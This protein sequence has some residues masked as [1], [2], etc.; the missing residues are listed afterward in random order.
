MEEVRPNF[1]FVGAARTGSTSLWNWLNQHPDVFM[2]PVKEPHHFGTHPG[3]KNWNAY[4]RLFRD[5]AGKSVVGEASVSYLLQPGVPAQIRETLGPVK[6]VGMLRQNADRLYSAWVQALGNGR[7]RG[8]SFEAAVRRDLRGDRPA[9]YGYRAMGFVEG[10]KYAPAVA[11]YYEVFG[12]E[13]VRM[14][15]TDDLH[16]DGGRAGVFGDLCGFLGITH[17]VRVD[18]RP[19]N[20]S[21]EKLPRFPGLQMAMAQFKDMA[22]GPVL[23]PLGNAVRRYPMGWNIAMGRPR[24]P[25]SPALRAELTELYRSDIQELGGLLGRDMSAWLRPRGEA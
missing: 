23:S 15:L 21:P 20:A 10:G 25:L 12:R 18:L 19:S 1:I 14:Y 6:I 4:L 24:P 9:G 22:F 17:D 3:I 13:N 16:G 5:G 7:L 11:R 8:G 2:S